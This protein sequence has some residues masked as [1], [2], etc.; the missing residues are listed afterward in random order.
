[1]PER[2]R[3]AAEPTDP[4]VLPVHYEHDTTTG[5]GASSTDQHLVVDA[6]DTWIAVCPDEPTAAELVRRLNEGGTGESDYEDARQS[7][8][9]DAAQFIQ[10]ATQ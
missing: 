2:A 7:A 9:R 1:M 10:K 3:E 5:H 8:L 6:T 4:I